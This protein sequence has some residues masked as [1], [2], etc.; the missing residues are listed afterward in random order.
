M[1]LSKCGLPLLRPLKTMTLTYAAWPSSKILQDNRLMLSALLTTPMNLLLVDQMIDQ[2]EFSG[3]ATLVNK[4]AK[5]R[6]KTSSRMTS[7]S[8]REI[9]NTK[10]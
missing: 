9:C 6:Q 3:K 8:T 2:S 1:D 4:V 10:V 7:I 5:K